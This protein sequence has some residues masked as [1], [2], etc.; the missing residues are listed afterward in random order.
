MSDW[1][2]FKQWY[3]NL[4]RGERYFVILFVCVIIIAV[5]MWVTHTPKER[6]QNLPIKLGIKY[7]RY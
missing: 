3:N 6:K 7:E 5:L 2:K 4:Y 1:Y